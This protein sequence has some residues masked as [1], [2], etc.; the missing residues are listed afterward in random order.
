MESEAATVGQLVDLFPFQRPCRHT[1]AGHARPPTSE[2]RQSHP[3]G[4]EGVRGKAGVSGIESTQSL[5]PQPLR[6]YGSRT[7][8]IVLP[9]ECPPPPPP[10]IY[11]VFFSYPLPNYVNF[12]VIRCVETESS[13]SQQY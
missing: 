2:L 10:H 12:K 11:T 4:P 9:G 1:Q 8:L 5:S 7:V 3:G 13:S 6:S